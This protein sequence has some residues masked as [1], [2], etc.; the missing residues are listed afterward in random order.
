MA[1]LS[2]WSLQ[3]DLWQQVKETLQGADWRSTWLDSLFQDSVPA[4]P[5]VYMIHTAQ[6][7]LS[8]TYHL[9]KEISGVLYVGRSTNLRTRFK[10]HA[11]LHPDNRHLEVCGNIFGLLRFAFTPASSTD[12]VSP[13]DWIAAAEH[14]LVSVLNPPANRNIPTGSKLVGRIGKAVPAA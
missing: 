13:N 12:S 4:V 3:V 1:H 8:H 9:P 14:I 10:Q 2:G 6:H 7:A 5:G 11:I